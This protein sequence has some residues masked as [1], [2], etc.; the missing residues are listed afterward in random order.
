MTI[1]PIIN[2]KMNWSDKDFSRAKL[3]DRAW[4]GVQTHTYVFLSNLMTHPS[5]VRHKQC[6]GSC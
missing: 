4:D 1:K 5:L 2:K 6:D 3:L